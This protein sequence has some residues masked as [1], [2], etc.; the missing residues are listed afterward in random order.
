MICPNSAIK[1][2]IK[3]YNDFKSIYVKS[4]FQLVFEK[5]DVF[6]LSYNLDKIDPNTHTARILRK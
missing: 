6:A 1:R 3:L 4:E 2:T 5:P